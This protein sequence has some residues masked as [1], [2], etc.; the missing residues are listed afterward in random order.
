M[1]QVPVDEHR[2]GLT[3]LVCLILVNSEL[4]GWGIVQTKWTFTTS[5]D[6]QWAGVEPCPALAEILTRTPDASSR[7]GN[8]TEV[9]DLMV[10]RECSSSSGIYLLHGKALADALAEPTPLLKVRSTAL[11]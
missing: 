6:G 8:F 4:T 5:A 7:L 11:I 9:P 2:D 10:V 3:C 1:A